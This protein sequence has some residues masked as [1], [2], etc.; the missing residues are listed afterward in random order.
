MAVEN[1]FGLRVIKK[2][3][4]VAF[5]YEM[6]IGNQRKRSVVVFDPGA[7]VS[8]SSMWKIAEDSLM[9]NPE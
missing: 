6:K 9:Q 7:K 1:T 8:S 2:S 3:A 5:P 4:A